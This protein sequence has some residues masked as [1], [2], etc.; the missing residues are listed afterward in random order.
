MRLSKAIERADRMRPNNVPEPDK[1]QW[2]WLIETEYA[3]MMGQDVPEWTAFEDPEL[4][5]PAQFEQVYIYYLAA[6]I[7]HYQEEIDLYQIDSMMAAQL[8][9]NIK[10]WW[11]RNGET[12][13]AVPERIKGVWI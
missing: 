4:I 3:E 1:K 2:L 7:D 13:T 8:D 9:D 10:R 11:A 12:K 5:L 6:H